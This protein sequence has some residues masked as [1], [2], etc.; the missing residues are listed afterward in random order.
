MKKLV[1]KFAVGKHKKVDTFQWHLDKEIPYFSS[2][3]P[4][5]HF[6]DAPELAN[7]PASSSKQAARATPKG[8]VPP[9]LCRRFR[10]CKSTG[11]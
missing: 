8:L 9:A 6:K 7:T 2:K 3:S 5:N 10:K 4:E 1:V 11:I